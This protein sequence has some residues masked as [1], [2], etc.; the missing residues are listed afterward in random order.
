MSNAAE[1]PTAKPDEREIYK[2]FICP[3]CGLPRGPCACSFPDNGVASYYRRLHR[4][5]KAEEPTP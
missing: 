2:P 1:K 3:D 4:K 5:K